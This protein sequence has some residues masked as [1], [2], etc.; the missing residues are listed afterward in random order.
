MFVR[1]LLTLLEIQITS[2]TETNEL[3][4]GKDNDQLVLHSLVIPSVIT[5]KFSERLVS[6]Y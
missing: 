5:I 4:N 2:F 1:L 6:E 3:I